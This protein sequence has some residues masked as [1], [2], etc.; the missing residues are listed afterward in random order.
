[1]QRANSLEKTLM[2]GKIEGRRRRG[3]QKTRWLDGITDYEFQQTPGNSVGQESLACC[4]SWGHK[5]LDMTEQLNNNNT[6]KFWFK[7]RNL[8]TLKPDQSTQRDQVTSSPC[9]HSQNLH[10]VSASRISSRNP[11][12]TGKKVS[13]SPHFKFTFPTR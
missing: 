5:E 6:Q 8:I 4:S 13:H 11:V 7:S 3:H 12:I 10:G 1:M 9:S 2:L